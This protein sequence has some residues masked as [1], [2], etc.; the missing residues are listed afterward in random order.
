VYAGATTNAKDLS[1]TAACT[2]K[3]SGGPSG[4]SPGLNARKQCDFNA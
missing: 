3:K 2:H 1:Q 4:G